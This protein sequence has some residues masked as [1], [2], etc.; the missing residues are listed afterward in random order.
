MKKRSLIILAAV[1]VSA[2]CSNN[3]EW[4]KEGVA[5]E[6]V[7]RELADCK[8]VAREATARDTNIITDIMATRGHDWQNTGVMDTHVAA[9]QNE[10]TNRSGDIVD[11]CMIGKGF[12]PGG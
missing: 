1:L 12:V 3:P 4:S 6:A 5:P 2:G 7:A 10:D 9:F 8:S 11:R